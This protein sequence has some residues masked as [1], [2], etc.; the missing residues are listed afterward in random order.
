MDLAARI[1][2]GS[3]EAQA[4]QVVKVEV[5]EQHV[6]SRRAFGAHRDPERTHAR[7]RIEHQHLAAVP[8]DFHA[9][10]IAAVSER[11]GAR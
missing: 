4:L 5:A 6:D 3:E 10:R 11:V 8:S 7:A 2:E 1:E 9:G